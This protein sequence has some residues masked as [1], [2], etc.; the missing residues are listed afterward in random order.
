MNYSAAIF[1][2]DGTLLDSTWVWGRVDEEFHKMIG[3]VKTVK[4]SENIMHMPP[5]ECAKYTKKI[6]NLSETIDEIKMIWYNIAKDLYLNEVELKLGAKQLLETMKMQGVH[7]S[8]ATSCYAE[9]A[10]L[11]LKRHGVYDMFEH[12]LY[13]DK[14]GVNKESA[15][16]YKLA[17]EYMGVLPENCA[18]FE[19]ILKPLKLVKD[20][21]MGYFA[22]DDRQTNETKR[23][24]QKNA[25]HYI[26]DF[27]DFMSSGNFERFFC[28]KEVI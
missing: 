12:F 18:V 28:L 10:E 20:C 19:D 17:A 3:A 13:S 9:I 16:I 21:G 14:L 5:T 24:L 22:V 7:I 8:L 23:A 15:D 1:D 26:F 6:Y 25:D 27:N 4:Y 2:M 11:I